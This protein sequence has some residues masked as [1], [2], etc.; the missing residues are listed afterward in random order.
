MPKLIGHLNTAT[1]NI[2]IIIKLARRHPAEVSMLLRSMCV[3]NSHTQKKIKVSQDP[4]PARLKP[5]PQ[6]HS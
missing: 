1:H 5:C 6:A 3:K 4:I 2:N